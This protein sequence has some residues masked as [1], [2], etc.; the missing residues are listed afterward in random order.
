MLVWLLFPVSLAGTATLH[1]SV[2]HAAGTTE[3]IAVPDGVGPCARDDG[4]VRC[5]TDVPIRFRWDGADDWT[6]SGVMVVAPGQTGRAFVLTA[7]R[8]EDEQAAFLQALLDDVQVD[9]HEITRLRELTVYTSDWTPP[10]PTRAAL[11]AHTALLRHRDAKVRREALEGLHPFVAGTSFDPTPREAP[12]P[13]YV[14]NL[15]ALAMDPDVGVRKRL[16]RILRDARPDIPR[17]DVARLLEL[18]LQDPHAGVRRAAVVGLTGAVD[19]DAMTAEHAW[20]LVLARVPEPP[21]AGRAAANQLASL[22]SRLLR[23]GTEVDVVAALELVLAHHPE[24]AWRVWSTWKQE[25]PVKE[26]W[27]RRLLDD[28]VGMDPVLVGHWQE[29]ASDVL[30]RVVAEWTPERHPER[31]DLL[32]RLRD[33][34]AE[35]A[36]DPSSAVSEGNPEEP[37]AD[38]S[39]SGPPEAPPGP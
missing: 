14:E 2:P 32:R 33:A 20:S 9:R 24:R 26:A 7:P 16:A 27:I 34:P 21:P 39:L 22:R 11:Q 5:D 4:F 18:L 15:D 10:Y 3:D 6:L 17:Q 28:T 30:D 12:S 1:V 36:A 38:D 35:P 25:L 37:A 29:H 8:E 19:R 13:L 31:A 23:E